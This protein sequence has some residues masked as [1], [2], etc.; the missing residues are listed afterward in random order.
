[1]IRP[2][3]LAPLL[4]GA[5]LAAS[6]Y[7]WLAEKDRWQAPPARMPELPQLAP[8]PQP[9]PATARQALARPPLWA[10]RRPVEQ[11]GKKGGLERELTQSRLTAV[12]ESGSQR[13]ALLQ[14]PDG[15]AL[16]LTDQS[17]PWRV[18]SFDGR[19]ALFVS[20]DGAQRIE[21]PLEAGSRAAPPMRAGAGRR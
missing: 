11:D 18:E 21:R 3:H 10:S 14:R 2:W 1:M 8:L 15:S 5:A 4:A 6:A 20:E 19:K 9:Q 13:V 7:W 17:K 12:F 16:K